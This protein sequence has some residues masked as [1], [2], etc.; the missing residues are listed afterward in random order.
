MPPDWT[1]G[2]YAVRYVLTSGPDAGRM[3]PGWFVVREVP[4]AS[5]APILV[6]APAMTW[7]AYNGWGGGSVYEFN[8]PA[9][10]PAVKVAFDRPYDPTSLG[11]NAWELPLVEFLEQEGFDVAYETDL[12][13]AR[14]PGSLEGRELIVVAGHGEY[15]PAELRTAFER[16]RDTGTSLAFMGA[17]A[18]YWQVR[19]ED[20]FTTMVAY[21][22]AALDPEQNPA[23]ETIL[24]RALVPPLPECAL[25]G[26]QHQGGTLDWPNDGDYVVEESAAGNPWIQ[27]AGLVPGDVLR[28][29]VSREVD[30]IPTWLPRDVGCDNHPTVL[31]HRERG[32][33]VDGDADSTVYVASSH[34]KVFASGSHQFVWG[35][36]DVP[37]IEMGHGR[38]DE[39]LRRFVAAMLDDMAP[40]G[41]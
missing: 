24:F 15:W 23:L 6:L 26:V 28:G 36:E 13:A 10:H 38:I 8:S 19:L 34:A 35:L 2:Y 12:Q 9:G 14:D 41:R 16:A 32:A 20:D 11:H 25:I 5:R 30:A 39:R 17:N 18:A 4:V 27:A 22:S 3:H 7:Q 40:R 33:D 29:L 37:D 21:K 1:S 31:F